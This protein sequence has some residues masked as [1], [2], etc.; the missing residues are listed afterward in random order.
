MNRI[1][2]LLATFILIGLNA[3]SQIIGLPNGLTEEEKLLMPQYLQNASQRSVQGISVPPSSPIRAMAEW[4]EIDAI[5]IAWTSYT[6]TLKEI[7]RYAQAESKVYILC[8][9]SNTVI[10]YL[11]QSPAV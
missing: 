5:M 3:S 1:F 6:A 4:E 10:S 8:S 9:D 2:T 7:V 11:H